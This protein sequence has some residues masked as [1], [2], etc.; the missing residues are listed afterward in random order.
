[1]EYR[2][3]IKWFVREI[4]SGKCICLQLYPNLAALATL[5]LLWLEFVLMML[6]Y[7]F[8]L[9][10]KLDDRT[11]DVAIQEVEVAA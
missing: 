2:R 9:F 6:L 10:D 7:T 8:D 4:G 3:S 1:M 11:V 5:G